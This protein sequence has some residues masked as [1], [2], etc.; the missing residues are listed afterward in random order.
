M[1][2][3]NGIHA[4]RERNPRTESMRAADVT[5]GISGKLLLSR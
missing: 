4:R 5:Y 2:A 3:A 1:T